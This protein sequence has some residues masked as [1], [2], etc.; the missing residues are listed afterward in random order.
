MEEQQ[1][2]TSRMSR[3]VRVEL[4]TRQNIY[5]YI[6]DKKTSDEDH[7][8]RNFHKRAVFAIGIAQIV[9]AVAAIIAQIILMTTDQELSNV[10]CGIWSGLAFG[11][12]GVM[13][14]FST[15]K[16]TRCTM[17]TLLVM[18]V[19]A[20]T[21]TLPLLAVSWSGIVQ[22]TANAEST[23]RIS[24]EV[25]AFAS[26]MFIAAVEALVSVT[27]AVI[28]CR[29]TCCRIREKYARVFM[30][31]QDQELP[32]SPINTVSNSMEAE[33]T[34]SLKTPI[35][36]DSFDTME[37]RTPRGSLTSSAIPKKARN[38]LLKM[39]EPNQTSSRVDYEAQRISIEEG[40]LSPAVYSIAN[41]DFDSVSPEP[42]NQRFFSIVDDGS[43]V[44]PP[45]TEDK[46]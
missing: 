45:P 10:G 33:K 8:E 18:S 23:E 25:A 1:S 17:I 46:T 42:R 32:Q 37:F 11:V 28:C 41:S 34:T 20:A 31:G 15:R 30:Q 22:A 14:V 19:V 36:Q 3:G 29:V 35:H 44:T 13:G 43:L 12:S 21:F 2:T 6:M 16:T 9:L 5:V 27:A 4:P 39:P 7:Y 38:L 26:L 40:G 24:A